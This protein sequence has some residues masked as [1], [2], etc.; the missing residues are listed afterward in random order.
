MYFI[1]TDADGF[2]TGLYKGDK[3][4]VHRITG[5]P[6]AGAVQIPDD[7]IKIG[8]PCYDLIMNPT[9]QRPKWDGTCIV[10]STETSL[11]LKKKALFNANMDNILAIE[12]ARIDGLTETQIDSELGV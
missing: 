2:V 6:I 5:E 9:G 10:L 12:S 4:Y 1:T 3:D 11:E 8:Q 7:A